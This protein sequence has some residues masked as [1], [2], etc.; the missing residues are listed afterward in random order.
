MCFIKVR[1][2]IY[3]GEHA[4]IPWD[5]GNGCRASP[6]WDR[7]MGWSRTGDDKRDIRR[8]KATVDDFVAAQRHRVQQGSTSFNSLAPSHSNVNT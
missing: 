5:R 6:G 8:R 1:F 2:G 7:V 4:A 3:P